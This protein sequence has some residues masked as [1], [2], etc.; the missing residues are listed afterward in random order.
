MGSPGLCGD[1]QVASHGIYA[2][3]Q[4]K[5]LEGLPLL[6]AEDAREEE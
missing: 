4:P 1:Q 2:R 3:G 5:G 6:S